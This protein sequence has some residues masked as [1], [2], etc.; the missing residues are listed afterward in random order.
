MTFSI[1]ARDAV[2]GDLGIAVASKFLAVGSV[3]PSARAGVGAVA[4]QASA[5]VAYGPDG[6]AL[7]AS[8][9]G[10]AEALARLVAADPERARGRPG[11]WT[12]RAARRRTRARPASPGPAAG[13]RTAWRPR[14]TS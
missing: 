4:T 6:L 13:P 14:A 5:N 3:V 8:G 9:V 10:A 1:V 2:T 11:S 12:L 7:L